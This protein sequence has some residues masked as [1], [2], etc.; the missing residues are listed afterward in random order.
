VRHYDGW[1]W[2]QAEVGAV[3]RVCRRLHEALLVGVWRHVLAISDSVWRP[4][5]QP[6]CRLGVE[7]RWVRGEYARTWR[8]RRQVAGKV[9][10]CG[11][12]DAMALLAMA[13][14]GGH[15][16]AARERVWRLSLPVIVLV[17]VWRR[18][19]RQG[20]SGVETCE[21]CGVCE[22]WRPREGR[23]ERVWRRDAATV[24]AAGCG[25]GS[26][27]SATRRVWRQRRW[28]SGGCGGHEQA[29]YL[30]CGGRQWRHG[31]WGHDHG[32]C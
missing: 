14:C 19:N 27:C 13:G 31:V 4:G 30:G 32:L 28:D 22:V 6:H 2:R 25:D 9:A 3:Y 21:G 18:G 24:G 20:F 7:T 23:S 17:R 15:A 10:G 1:V 12:D 5:R 29:I 26:S 16:K 11:D 8:V